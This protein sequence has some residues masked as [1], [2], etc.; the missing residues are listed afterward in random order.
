MIIWNKGSATL[1]DPV[2]FV[3]VIA[4][5]LLQ[6]RARESRVEDQAISSWQNAAN[7]RPIPRELAACP[8]SSGCCVAL[9]VRVRRARSSRSPFILGLR[10]TNLAAAVAH[11]R[12]RRD[13]ARAAH[14]LG[15]RDQPRAGRV[16]RHRRGRGRARRTCTGSSIRSSASCSRPAIGAVGVGDHRAARAAHPRPDARGHDAR[17]RRRDVVV[18][19]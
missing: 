16:R 9:R 11:L 19:A 6:R 5:L 18:P 1:V 17:V 13:L 8:R 15:R 7:V 4:A 3:I 2:M 14:G 10:D 12:H